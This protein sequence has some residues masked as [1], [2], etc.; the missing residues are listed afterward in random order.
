MK[1]KFLLTMARDGMSATCVFD[2]ENL[3]WMAMDPTFNLPK[4]FK[5]ISLLELQIMYEDGGMYYFRPPWPQRK[6]FWRKLCELFV[7]D[8]ED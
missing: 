1:T 5:P 3:Q 7:R 6:S 4:V 2:V 8:E